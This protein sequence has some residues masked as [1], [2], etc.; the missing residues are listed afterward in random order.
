VISKLARKE[1]RYWAW[2]MLQ[3]RSGH[4]MRKRR[5]GQRFIRMFSERRPPDRVLEL[6]L[7]P[8]SDPR[9]PPILALVEAR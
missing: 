1:L 7:A 9:I 4:R 6:L 2:A 8:L 3:P 5:K